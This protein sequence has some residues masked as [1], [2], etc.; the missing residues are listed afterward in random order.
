MRTWGIVI[1]ALPALLFL[2]GPAPLGRTQEVDKDA[3]DKAVAAAVRFLRANQAAPG[4][5]VHRSG[6][7]DQEWNI[8]ATAL[9]GLALLESDVPRDDKM[10]TE[11]A[12]IVR[13]AVPRLTKTYSISLAVIFLDR[14]RHGK[15]PEL[16]RR[17][18][19]RLAA[20]QNQGDG[21]W[22]YDVPHLTPQQEA[23]WMATL[24]RLR[25]VK[26]V[27]G[28]GQQ[29]S[30]L[31]SDNSNTQFAVL[32]L[33]VARV[34]DVPVD[35]PLLLA[36]WRF[37]RTQREDG[38]WNYGMNI[39]VGGSQESTPSM[40][41][42]GLLGLAI[43]YGTKREQAAVLRAGGDNPD[44]SEP[45]PPPPSP[46]LDIDSDPAV[47][48]AKGYIAHALTRS[49]RDITHFLY[50]LWSLER[51]SVT[52]RWKDYNG[53]D[54]YN[55]GA[56][57]L[58][59]S[60]QQNGSW[61]IEETPNIDTAFALL[62]LRKAN[63]VGDISGTA[64]LRSGTYDPLKAATVQDPVTGGAKKPATNRPVREIAPDKAEAEA[65]KLSGEFLISRPQRQR[66]ILEILQ[67]T[68]DSTGNF[69]QA[70]IDLIGQAKDE[71]KEMVRRALAERLSR[72]TL[73]SL[74]KRLSEN[75]VEVRLAVVRA[76]G[77]KGDQKA[78]PELVKLLTDSNE[79]IAEAAE[80]SL[81]ALSD[82]KDFGRN[83]QR[84][85]EYIDKLRIR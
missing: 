45:K 37:R 77:M 54:W 58:L 50:F 14:Y 46:R 84:W 69:T 48:K 5:W 13:A 18:A 85:Q 33:W 15:D 40:T 64:I 9:V 3:I 76:M 12:A 49:P 34:H 23:Q 30:G 55:Y 83:P 8:G 66:E 1:A 27:Q 41:C 6:G 26:N 56:N 74:V 21:G 52:Y 73:A 2:A 32:A 28:T 80:E 39:G 11:A 7:P 79:D 20:A 29:G 35:Y 63:L 43:A 67:D 78:M 81:K 42:A 16:V 70:L 65:K 38:G 60:Q 36:E 31:S 82:G 71:Q 72:Q 25:N 19:V 22:S 51:V 59:R 57:I 68:K 53:I 4:F 61:M 24:K 75:D 47:I 62:F 17:M 10:I 44:G